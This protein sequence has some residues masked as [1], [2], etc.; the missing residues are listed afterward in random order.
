[1]INEIKWRRMYEHPTPFLKQKSGQ[2]PPSFIGSHLNG[3]ETPL[4]IG[5]HLNGG[6]T[7]LSI[8]SHL[9]GG[10][11]PLLAILA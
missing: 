5:S 6:E 8:G 4:S 7:P 1:M 11:T 10:E 9:N 2:S 3:G